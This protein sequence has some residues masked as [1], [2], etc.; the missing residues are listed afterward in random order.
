LIDTSVFQGKSERIFID[1][2][3]TLCQTHSRIDH[4]H[5]LEDGELEYF[6]VD[7]LTEERTHLF[8]IAKKGMIIGWEALIP[9]ERHIVN[10]SIKS[11]K[12]TLTKIKKEDFLD[13]LSP[14]LLIEL[15]QQIQHLL[16]TSLYKQTNLLST[17]VKQRAVQLENYFISQYS[18]I[19]ERIFLL[20]GSPFFGEFEEDE[21]AAL[22]ELMERREYEANELIYDQDENS[23][24][25]F[26]LIQG[27][28]SMR[29]QEGETYLNL[30]S[31]STPGYIF[32]WS[33]TFGLSD[34][35]RAST[36]YKTSVYFISFK[37]LKPIVESSRFGI[38]FY[39]N[40]I[41][42]LGNQFQL[43]NSRYIYL[44]DD[45]NLVSVKHLIEINSP[46]IPL[47]SPLH[48]I[49][50]LLKDFSTQSL[51][52]SNLHKLHKNGTKQERH[53]SS[54]CLDLLKTEEREMLF[55]ESIAE[56]YKTVSTGSPDNAF[57]NRINCAKKTRDVF[58]HLSVHIEGEEHLPEQPGNIFVYNH[59]LNHPL[60]TLN[61]KF[62]LT[63]DS[64]FISS[65]ILD[66]NYND[67][68]IRT[69][70]FG[71][72]SEY[73]HQ[74]YYENLG[75]ITV[76]TGDS[77][78][79]SEQSKKEAKERFYQEAED[80]L[81]QGINLIIS[82]EGTS[83]VSE[84]SPGPFK[85]GPF[86][87]AERAIIEPYIVPIVLYNFDKRITE[88]LLFCRILPPF[89]ISER[90]LPDETLKQFVKRY[91]QDF[92]NEVVRAGI[93]TEKLLKELT[94]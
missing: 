77:D 32:G 56:V 64:H 6:L 80:F 86:N 62:Q 79:Q 41:W 13:A 18:T 90:Q 27:E 52:F 15:C 31:I 10:I 4:L 28:V 35:C 78:L 20:R 12:A 76:Y 63:L 54:I 5:I 26:V 69:V 58:E 66:K 61:N 70:R 91:Q 57:E 68:G 22:A 55:M 23:S 82:P 48:Q 75:Y 50:H 19:E 37:K 60:Y 38:D 93:D 40:V 59:L 33:S 8:S 45:H 11:E 51:A 47:P 25:L 73:G 46:R 83:F 36:E 14:L 30:R 1:K 88:N 24:G 49:P 9:P 21:V 44:L 17:K 67:P 74:D 53:L 29:R 71:K 7:E 72:S 92:K 84:E 16:E 43:S 42:L 65:M 39:K 87:I 2:G 94:K 89:R 3:L 85:M 34:V 81:S